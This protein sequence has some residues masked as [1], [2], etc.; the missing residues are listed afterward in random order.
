MSEIWF[1]ADTHY[2]HANIVKGQSN[3]SDKE[4]CRDFATIEEHDE[5]LLENLNKCARPGDLLWHLGD[6][7]FGFCDRAKL[8][9]FR[10]RI[11]CRTV[12]LVLGN[13]DHLIENEKNTD[14]RGMFYRVKHLHYGKIN[15]RHFVLS[16]YSMRTWPWQRIGSIH[17]YGHSHGKLPSDGT[18]YSLDVGIDTFSDT[19]ER[20]HPY[21]FDEII[22]I[23]GPSLSGPRRL[24]D[25]QNASHSPPDS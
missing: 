11:R 6:F 24:R 10:K 2:G 14:I 12:G 20:Y 17:L 18:G 3:W 19:H 13:H 5:C 1:T 7:G 21:N 22:A 25:G 4:S 9:Q 8:V 23:C 15:L 16:H